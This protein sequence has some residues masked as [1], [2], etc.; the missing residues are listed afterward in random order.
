MTN[1]IYP[2]KRFWC[3]R[4]GRLNFTSEGFL[5]NSESKYG[6]INNPDVVPFDQISHFKCLI[7][8][9]EPGIGKTSALNKEIQKLH[10][11]KDKTL[12]I[13]LKAFG[14]ETSLYRNLFDNPDFIAWR[15]SKESLILIFDSLD[16][17]LLRMDNVAELLIE[18]LKKCPIDRLYLKIACRTGDWAKSF[19]IS[20]SDLWGKEN[21][22]I[23]ELVP[24][25]K[26]D[27]EQAAKM[28]NIDPNRFIKEL[29]SKKAVSLSIKPITLKFLLNRFKRY[30]E[31]S[32][33]QFDLY[34]DGCKLLCSENNESRIDSRRT[35]KLSSEQ[36]YIIATLIAAI[37][38][39]S[40]K[41]AIWTELD[42]G[43]IPEE[44][45]SIA[46][47]IKACGDN[48]DKFI[49]NESQIKEV[50]STGLFSAR[51]MHCLGW[52]HQTYA[53]FLAVQFILSNE[54]TTNQI[55][56]LLEHPFENGALVPQL[57]E[58]MSW[59]ASI[60]NDIFKRISAINPIILLHG[61]L[62]HICYE[63]KKQLI[64][65]ILKQFEN[66]K[67]V[68]WDWFGISKQYEKLDFPGIGELIF[69]IIV[70]HNEKVIVRENAIQIAEACGLKE[71]GD[72][73]L[74]ISLDKSEPIQIRKYAELFIE[75]LGNDDQKLKLLPLA[76]SELGDDPDDELKGIALRILWPDYL[77]TKDMFSLLKNPK[78]HNFLGTYRMFIAHGIIERMDIKH[79]SDGLKWVEMQPTQEQL[80]YPFR[81]FINAI[82]QKAWDNFYSPDIFTPFAAA[83]LSR[84]KQFNAL[85]FSS[86]L[87]NESEKRR[88]L[89]L[90]LIDLGPNEQNMRNLIFTNLTIK[91]DFFWLIDEF[92]KE[93][94]QEKQ[95]LLAKLIHSAFDANI[96]AQVIKLYKIVIN[97]PIIKSECGYIYNAVSLNS[98]QAKEQKDIYQR[99]REQTSLRSTERKNSAEGVTRYLERIR[100]GEVDNWL[101]LNIYM[102]NNDIS[103]LDSNLANL[104][105]WQLVNSSI[106]KEIM[107]A[108]KLYINTKNID[109]VNWLKTKRFGIE[110]IS[111]FRA[112]RLLILM[113]PEFISSLS[114]DLWMKWIPIILGYPV[115]TGSDEEKDEIL[116][117]TQAYHIVP[118]EIIR[119]L[120]SFIDDEDKK[121]KNT[122]IIRTVDKCWDQKLVNAIFNKLRLNDLELETMAT[123]LHELFTHN[124][125]STG[126]FIIS[127]L[128]PLNTPEDKVDWSRTSAIISELLIFQPGE[129]WAVIWGK[130]QSQ[131][132][133]GKQLF[134]RF[135]TRIA[136]LGQTLKLEEK[137]L[138]DL[139]IWLSNEFPMD[140]DP[141][142]D[143][144]LGAHF[145]TPRENVATFR[146]SI[147]RN[148]SEM[149]TIKSLQSVKI[150]VRTLPQLPS[151]KW[152]LLTSQFNTRK[153]TW[154][155]PRPKEVVQ[156]LANNNN[157]LV[158]SSEQL[159][160]VIIDSLYRLEQKLHGETPRTF[161]LWI[162]AGDGKY[163]PR[164]EVEFS[165][166]IKGHLE[167]DLQNR[168]IIL[169]REVEIRRTQGSN[170]GERT[171]ILV[172]A[173]IKNHQND[174][175][176]EVSVVIEI[177]GNWNPG[178]MTAMEEQ[179]VNRYLRNNKTDCGLYL[180]GWFDCKKWIDEDRKKRKDQMTLEKAKDFFEKQ[181]LSL[182][183]DHKV[184]KSFVLD[185]RY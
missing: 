151:L 68:Y 26:S 100:K 81:D 93:K 17:C 22:G 32:N 169:N 179:L 20:L 70:D 13:D 128:L 119:Y 102:A 90:K 135:S 134:E 139:Y 11:A 175:L 125:K 91:N 79:L 60:R 67:V 76:K 51:D 108:S 39:F 170:Q 40:N 29:L 126:E 123:L 7:L 5:S 118:N 24:L 65:G 95:I 64:L 8:L 143:N 185:V 109:V 83:V 99:N 15:K 130:I 92:L 155:P 71:F 129:Y 144:D 23:Y 133:F 63:D 28:N 2:W 1:L 167:D 4:D 9:G 148:L 75:K 52:A 16:E 120:L 12:F 85:P 69:P 106:K 110:Q 18:E 56:S 37:T 19:E 66:D 14:S 111:Q 171:D 138:A 43:D 97:Q 114:K 98:V 168:G 47:I 183:D 150:I 113:D 184:I 103:N 38:V 50:L 152:M 49:L 41:F 162:D 72:S 82:L 105:I 30:G 136:H 154:I 89:L 174:D 158:G 132:N 145:V 73:I 104:P 181:A 36:R 21:I 112:F 173:V 53:D 10:K 172:N 87:L 61:D 27:I 107:D 182:S 161:L 55:M 137:Q 163:K 121:L 35:G 74:K 33:D 62:T 96:P 178:L 101:Q 176:G 78:R 59:V 48:N 42:Y 177:K 54:A 46:E 180:V 147:I 140:E 6:N 159:L 84:I 94:D 166:F 86:S 34:K 80:D 57:Y 115:S 122:F 160:N 44:D 127:C 45:V 164:K 77:A 141:N 156:L 149:G 165:D 124:I 157:R 153:R 117:I 142:H 31:F 146:D 88:K 25:R 131:T 3:T 116:L 58:V